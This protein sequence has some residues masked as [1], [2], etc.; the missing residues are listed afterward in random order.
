[1]PKSGAAPVQIASLG[2]QRIVQTQPGTKTIPQGATIVK[3]VNAQVVLTS[4]W[5]IYSSTP[6]GQPVINKAAAGAIQV[7][8]I[9]KPGQELVGA[10]QQIIRAGSGQIMVTKSQAETQTMMVRGKPVNT[11]QVIPVSDWLS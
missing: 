7:R 8:A 6:Q 2:G 3:L 4:D 9:N 10:G 11:N 5:L 1:M